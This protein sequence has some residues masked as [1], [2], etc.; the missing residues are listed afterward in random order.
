M[1][2][3]LKDDKEPSDLLGP[4]G[5]LKQLTAA[6]VER[7]S[8]RW[9]ADGPPGYEKHERPKKTS[10][11]A[12]NGTTKKTLKTEHGE[13]PIQV[14]RDRDGTFEPAIVRSARRG[15]TASTTGSCRCTRAG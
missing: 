12:Q 2:E 9:H 13:V 4:K 15:L 7:A 8:P 14:P 10:N 11:N 5:F 1:D 6:L 3:L